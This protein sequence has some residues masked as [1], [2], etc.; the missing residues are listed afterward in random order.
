MQYKRPDAGR[1]R[2]RSKHSAI[3]P[4]CNC[5][6]RWSGQRRLS[7][8]KGMTWVLRPL[9]RRNGS[10]RRSKLSTIVSLVESTGHSRHQCSVKAQHQLTLRKD[11]N[12]LPGQVNVYSES[13][14]PTSGTVSAELESQ[15]GRRIQ[16]Y[17]S[18]LQSRERVSLPRDG[19]DDWRSAGLTHACAELVV[20]MVLMSKN[21]SLTSCLHIRSLRIQMR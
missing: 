1:H 3:G 6:D 4:G 11:E 20:L 19:G 18:K 15:C 10:Y 7:A 2:K 5:G 8:G 9:V 17:R 21:V 14:R 16:W 12:E 13:R